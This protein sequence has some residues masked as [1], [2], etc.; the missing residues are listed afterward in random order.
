MLG[1]GCEPAGLS[2]QK[3]RYILLIACRL[4]PR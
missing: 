2:R 3:N 1:W 4:R